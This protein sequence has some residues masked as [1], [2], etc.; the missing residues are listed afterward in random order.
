MK[1]S[2][3]KQLSP[4][5]AAFLGLDNS[6]MTG[7]IT[8]ILVLD[9]AAVDEPFD[10]AHLL[11]FLGGRIGRVRAF[12]QRLVEVP[13]GLDRPYWVDDDRFDL[14]YHVRESA[15]PRPGGMAQL[16]EL[17]GRLHERPLDMTR[18]LW[19]AYLVTGLEGGRVAII[20][21]THHV[22]I[23]GVSG[24]EVL[25]A[26]IDLQPTPPAPPASDDFE[27]APAPSGVSLLARSAVG[28]LRRP[29]QAWTVVSGLAKWAPA[30][31]PFDALKP[32]NPLAPKKTGSA[33]GGDALPVRPPT[34]SFNAQISRRRRVGV[35]DLPLA[36]VRAVKN[37]FGTSVNDVVMA[38][39]AG[40]LRHW[41][42]H[43]GGILSAPLVAMVP[44]AVQAER[45]DQGN[46]VTAMFTTLPTHLDDPVARLKRSSGFSRSAK[47]KKGAV[48]PDVLTSAMEFAPPVIFGRAARAVFETGLF[49]AMRPFNLV[50]S[51]VPGG[52]EQAY[53]AGAKLEA[54]YPVSVLTD[55][56]GL[57]VT[58]LGYRDN[59]H[60]GITTDPDLVPDPQGIADQMVQELRT[61]LDAAEQLPDA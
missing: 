8:S 49:R 39:T 58:L 10:L 40:A 37:A 42:L 53:V 19:E 28:M 4:L 12:R 9:P 35:A 41:L 59:L 17:A 1:R 47:K 50:I 5:D 7:N 23:D 48:P 25:T 51:N 24:M 13:L 52:S 33:A 20:N 55:G 14:R 34:T 43:D 26:L 32:R 44:V 27:P 60:V 3:V 16:L 38:V 21:K 31:L 2:T 56:L 30:V 22:V 18:P 29:E 45:S 11:E 6:T 57:N 46:F 15:L 36:D 54:I 61:L